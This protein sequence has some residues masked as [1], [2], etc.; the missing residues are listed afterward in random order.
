[1]AVNKS[2]EIVVETREEERSPEQFMYS[3]SDAYSIDQTLIMTFLSQRLIAVQHVWVG[4]S[5]RRHIYVNSGGQRAYRTGRPIHHHLD[6]NSYHSTFVT[7]SLR[8]G[9]VLTCLSLHERPPRGVEMFENDIWWRSPTMVG[10]LR[11][12]SRNTGLISWLWR[13]MIRSSFVTSHFKKFC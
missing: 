10:S 11:Q 4:R 13:E 3:F 6:Q 7:L 12:S 5:G 8:R 9:S 2:W 1:M